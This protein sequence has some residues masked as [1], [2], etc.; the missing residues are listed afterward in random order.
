M[1]D[2]GQKSKEKGRDSRFSQEMS[3]LNARAPVAWHP[4]LVAGL[5]RE[6]P[7]DGGKLGIYYSRIGVIMTRFGPVELTGFAFGAY[8]T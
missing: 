3:C 2:A 4:A 5:G 8:W 6:K 7:C 1:A